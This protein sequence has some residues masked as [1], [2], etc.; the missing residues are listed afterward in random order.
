MQTG[1]LVLAIA[2]CVFAERWDQNN[3][4]VWFDWDHD[5]TY[6]FKKLPLSGQR[7]KRLPWSDNYWPNFEG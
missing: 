1:I 6:D 2:L 5:F 7:A 3:D 4:P